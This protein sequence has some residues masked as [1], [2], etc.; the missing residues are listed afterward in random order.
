MLHRVCCI[1]AQKLD[2]LS[3]Q[4]A[5]LPET[6]PGVRMIAQK[7]GGTLAALSLQFGMAA[8]ASSLSKSQ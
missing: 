3:S 6:P 4:V 2:F 5:R 7:L 1:I 8:R